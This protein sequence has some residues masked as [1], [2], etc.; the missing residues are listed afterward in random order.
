MTKKSSSTCNLFHV[1][2]N[3]WTVPKHPVLASCR[4]R[5]SGW[6]IF[7]SGVW[8]SVVILVILEISRLMSGWRVKSPGTVWD[9]PRPS[10]VQDHPCAVWGLHGRIGGPLAGPTDRPAARPDAG[11][12]TP[13]PHDTAPD[14]QQQYR[15]G[16]QPVPGRY[17]AATTAG[18]PPGLRR[19]RSGTA[20]LRQSRRV[21]YDAWDQIRR[22]SV[23][24]SCEPSALLCCCCRCRSAA[25]RGN[26]LRLS[27]IN[28]Q[29]F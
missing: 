19:N 13:V 11:P 20:L 24:T 29:T 18:T 10:G 22:G 28:Y 26:D 5:L 9:R 12:A 14:P 2:H 21:A 8:S 27:V 23:Q 17:P 3:L 1:G 4:C 7:G 16:T 15:T 6:S 25:A